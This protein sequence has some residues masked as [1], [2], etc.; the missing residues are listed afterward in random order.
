[1]NTEFHKKFSNIIAGTIS[2]FDRIIISG[3]L[4]K[5]GYAE[6]MGFHLNQ[7]GVKIKEYAEFAKKQ[8]DSVRQAVESVATSKNITIEHIRKPN[9]FDKEKNIQK[10]LLERGT[11]EGIVHIYTSMEICDAYEPK[12][13]KLN[14]KAY[15]KPRTTKC[16]HYYIYFIDKFLGLCFLRIPTWIPFRVQFYFNGHNYL[17]VLLQDNNIKYSMSDNA[18]SFVS[19]YQK[20][21]QLSDKIN[22][23]DIH[24]FL[25]HII[26]QYIPFLKT[27]DQHYRWT[28]TQA[29]YAT[30][31]V[32]KNS[33]DLI[34]IYDQLVYNCIHAVKPGNIATFFSRKLAANYEQNVC[35]NFNKQIQGTRIKHTIGVNSIKMYDKAKNILR[36]ETTVNDLTAF[37]VYRPVVT[38]DHKTVNRLASMKKSIYSLVKL[39]ECCLAANTRYLNFISS[40]QDY[41]SGVKNLDKVS[42]KI[43]SQNRSYKGFNFFDP[44]DAK[45][46][47]ALEAGEYNINGFRNKTLRAKLKNQSSSAAISRIIKRLLLHGIIKRIKNSYKYYLTKLGKLVLACA[48]IVKELRIIP[49]LAY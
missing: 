12:F 4:S 43:T 35:N 8:N 31:T 24:K 14:H 45:I 20:A 11:Q 41:S 48:H 39:A 25:D 17:A 15:L 27:T 34:P 13:D 37:K 16:L 7:Y 38:R 32:F 33:E 44:F 29:E 30:D 21:Q 23:V 6:S 46:L 1:M 2:C 19:D 18:F 40:F 47:L 26:K 22:P 36:V 49:A 9:H 42:Q 3:S 10:I 28:V 5:W